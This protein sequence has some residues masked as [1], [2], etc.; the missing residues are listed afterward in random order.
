M[1]KIIKF[2]FSYF[3][4]NAYTMV[5]M[6]ALLLLLSAVKHKIFSFKEMK[7]L[8]FYNAFMLVIGTSSASYISFIIGLVI[9]MSSQYKRGMN[10]GIVVFICIILYFIYSY[11]RNFIFELLFQDVL[12]K[13]KMVRGEKLFG[14]LLLNYGTKIHLWVMVLLWGSVVL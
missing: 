1:N 7:F 12:G 13:M 5:S 2:G 6:I 11:F 9:L 10:V 3:H 14:R 8:I 4:T